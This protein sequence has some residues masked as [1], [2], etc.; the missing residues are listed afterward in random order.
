M[1][2]DHAAF[3]LCASAIHGAAHGPDRVVE[4]D[5]DRLADQEMTDIEFHD[6]RKRRDRLGA[7]II[8]PMTGMHFKAEDLGKRR[9]DPDPF[10][11]ARGDV[12]LAGSQRIAPG[13]GMKFDHRRADR[14]RGLDLLAIRGNEQATRGCRPPP[15]PGPR[16]RRRLRWPTTSSPPSVVRSARRSG[17]RQA[18]CG[19]RAQRDLDHVV[20]RRHFEIQRL[21]DLGL[22]PRDVV[23]ADVAAVLA[24]M[25]GDAVGARGHGELRGA[26]RIGMPPAPRIADGGDVV[27]IH[28]KPEMR[29]LHEVR[30]SAI[31]ARHARDHGLRPQL[32]DDRRQMLE[33]IDLEIDG[34]RGEIGRRR[35][36]WMLSMLPSFSAMTCASCASEPG[37]LTDSTTIWAGKRCGSCSSTSQRKSSHCSGRSSNSC[38][39][40]DWIG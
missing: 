36:M 40:G 23:V 1:P 16:A 39:D 3:T 34:E 14:M 4:A 31:H 27:D 29:C 5:K 38:S 30:A 10:E 8:E 25:R 9:R 28:A 37:S 24:Q 35:S 15:R 21:V 6:L 26:H 33:V 19:L 17:T 18:A 2:P 11:F 20:G 7:R 13:A 22:E 12:V 32:R